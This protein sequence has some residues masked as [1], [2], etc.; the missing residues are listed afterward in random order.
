MTRFT[1]LIAAAALSTSVVV[2]L[3]PS[4]SANN[5]AAFFGGLAAGA[6]I[7]GA[8]AGGRPAPVYSQPYSPQPFY[9]RQCWYEAQPMFNQ[10]GY[11]VGTQ[12]V[13]RCN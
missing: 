9:D 2:G 10:F 6:F 4:A 7:A 5:T 12:T 13:R 1:R 11:Q 3:A 8:V